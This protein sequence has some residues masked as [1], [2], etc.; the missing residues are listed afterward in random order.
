LTLHLSTD[1]PLLLG[2]ACLVVRSVLPSVL[3]V[4]GTST[5]RQFRM[6]HKAESAEHI[7]PTK[8]ELSALSK[9]RFGSLQLTV[10]GRGLTVPTVPDW[11][12]ATSLP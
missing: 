9:N 3:A 7:P 12:E 4:G 11:F 1:Q 2:P 6:R 10:T 8:P 5:P